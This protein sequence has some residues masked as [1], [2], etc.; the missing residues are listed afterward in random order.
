LRLRYGLIAALGVLLFGGSVEAGQTGGGPYA[1]MR[2]GLGGRGSGLGGAYTSLANDGTSPYWNPAGLGFLTK[3]AVTATFNQTSA[4]VGAEL[5]QHF[6][7]SVAYPEPPIPFLDFLRV[8]F[9]KRGTLAL[10]FISF[11][12][13]D[14]EET[15]DDGFGEPVFSGNT[16]NS[17]QTAILFSYGVQVFDINSTP[18]M[19]AGFNLKYMSHTIGSFGSASPRFLIGG[20]DFGVE[21]DASAIVDRADRAFLWLFRDMRMGLV[22]RKNF[23]KKWDNGR[24]ESDPLFLA[25]GFSSKIFKTGGFDVLWALDLSR[26]SNGPSAFSTGIELGFNNLGNAQA[27]LRVGFRDHYFSGTGGPITATDLNANSGLTLGGGVRLSFVQL[28]AAYVTGGFQNQFR[29]SGSLLF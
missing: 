19:H 23:D 10:T 22:A 8:G 4:E 6:F 16:F 13:A 25:F 24:V 7:F 1:F 2:I 20:V 29:V 3:R 21:A 27:A 17:S 12:V 26:E 5:G 28:D 15:L 9:L 14:I 11:G 18:A